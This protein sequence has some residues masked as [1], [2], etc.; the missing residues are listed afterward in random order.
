MDVILI[1]IKKQTIKI[2]KPG[3]TNYMKFDNIFHQNSDQIDIFASE[4]LC[5]YILKTR[6]RCNDTNT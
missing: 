2:M 5:K 3:N 4:N 1:Y 6:S